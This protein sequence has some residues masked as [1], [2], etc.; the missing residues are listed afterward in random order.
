MRYIA[1]LFL[2]VT[3]FVWSQADVDPVFKYDDI[4]EKVWVDSIY[5]QLT[6]EEKV[7]QLFMVAAYSNKDSAHV[8]GI[9]KLIEDYKIGGLK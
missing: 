9:D 4:R 5:N 7:G 2:F 6:F 8:K 1:L 3:P